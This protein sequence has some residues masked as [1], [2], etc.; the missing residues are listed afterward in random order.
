MNSTKFTSLR[1]ASTL[2]ISHISIKKVEN[3]FINRFIKYQINYY[4]IIK[5]F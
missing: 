1:N 3:K 5:H 4:K 2:F